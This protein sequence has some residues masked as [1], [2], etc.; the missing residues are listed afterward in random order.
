MNG[1]NTLLKCPQMVLEVNGC[2]VPNRVNGDEVWGLGCRSGMS[3]TTP[4]RPSARAATNISIYIEVL[5]A[6]GYLVG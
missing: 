1:H 5:V 3:P 4:V 2:D 6:L